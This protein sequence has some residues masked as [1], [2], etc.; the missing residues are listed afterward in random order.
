M[1]YRWEIVCATQGHDE[2][3]I[4]YVVAS[5]DADVIAKLVEQRLRALVLTPQSWMVTRTHMEDIVQ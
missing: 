4:F 2:H 3:L 5:E 1:R